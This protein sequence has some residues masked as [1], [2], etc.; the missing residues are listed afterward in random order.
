MRCYGVGYKRLSSFGDKLKKCLLCTRPHKT[1]NHQYRV[2]GY[3]KKSGKLYM[4]IV[5][6][7]ANCM[8]NYQANFA[9]CLTRQKTEL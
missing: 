9:Y 3:S 7:C 6:R 5:A 8:D 4:H 1:S 2:D